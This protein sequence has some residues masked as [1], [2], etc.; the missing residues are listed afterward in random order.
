[1]RDRTAQLEA[2]NKELEGFAYSVAHDLRAPLR[3]IDGWSL[4]LVEDI[5]RP[6]GRRSAALPGAGAL[7]GAAHGPVDRR[8]PA[9]LP[10]L[11]ARA[12]RNRDSRGSH[13]FGAVDRR[14]PP[15]DPRGSPDRIRRSAGVDG[16]VATHG[17]LQS[18]F[19]QPAEQRRQ[20][21]GQTGRS[22]HRSRTDRERRPARVLRARQRRR[23]RYGIRPFAVR[24]FSAP[25]P[26]VRISQATGI[27]LATAQRIVHR[28]GGRVWAEAQVG[29]GATF[30]FTL[31]VTH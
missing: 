17:L 14:Q 26:V 31:E 10:Q 30:Y 22:A 2:S 6:V 1:V 24:T 28:H 20:V 18:C 29:R 27:G 7:G 21:H 3:G 11:R 23:L 19:D 9:A 25:A 5:G 4:A 8:P 12:A 15:G 16:L 13:G